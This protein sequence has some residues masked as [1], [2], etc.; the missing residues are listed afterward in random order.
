MAQILLDVGEG[1]QDDAAITQP[2]YLPRGC[3]QR[4][5]ASDLVY[6]LWPKDIHVTQALDLKR[7][8]IIGCRIRSIATSHEAS[9]ERVP[10]RSGDLDELHEQVVSMLARLTKREEAIICSQ[11]NPSL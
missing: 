7:T 9:I 2:A 8:G 10:D 11:H 4:P 6:K 3:R 5:L 1:N